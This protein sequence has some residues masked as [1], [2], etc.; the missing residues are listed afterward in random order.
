MRAILSK[1]PGLPDTLVLED[2]PSPTPGK[3]EIVVSVKAV[4]VNF[5]DFLIIQDMYQYKPQRPFSPGGEI[6]GV[7]KAVGDGVT[8]FKVGDKVLGLRKTKPDV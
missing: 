2:V 6:S 4:G 1:A 7:V 5:P 8:S 3:G